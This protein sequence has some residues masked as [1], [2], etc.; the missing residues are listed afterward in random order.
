MW[1]GPVRRL[2]G[3]AE[4]RLGCD[5]LA[6]VMTL[7]KAAHSMS[8]DGFIDDPRVHGWLRAGDTPSQVYPAFTM[9]V[10][11]PPLGVTPTELGHGPGTGRA[12]EMTAAFCRMNTSCFLIVHL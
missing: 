3:R 5:S 4:G 9:S 1:E 12:L 11:A 10:A 8:P 2:T 7:I 6:D